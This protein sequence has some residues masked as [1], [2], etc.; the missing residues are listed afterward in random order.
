[1]VRPR[2]PELPLTGL[3][4]AS[5]LGLLAIIAIGAVA[6]W[7]W[8][9]VLD[10]VAIT[11]AIRHYP[12]APLVFLILH[13]TASLFVVPRTMLAIVAGLLFGIGWGIFWT[14]LGAVAGA[15]AGF[16]AARYIN[17]GLIDVESVRHVGPVLERVERGGWRAVAILR[18]VP[19]M[20]HSLTNYAVGLTRLRLGAY[21]FGS[22]IG[23]LPMTIVY[24]EFGAAGE[25]L[26]LG[27]VGWL[28][29]TWIGFAAVF[30]SLLIPAYS[31]WRAR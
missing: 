15:A 3:R 29:P 25:R 9:A 7:R 21:L 2:R 22:L 31:R 26:M 12:A 20:P 24:V 16:L 1:M 8:R 18:L 10:P 6:A 5:R 11:A 23:Q 30:V 13:I 4:R 19:V 27:G 28:M 14:E 17:S